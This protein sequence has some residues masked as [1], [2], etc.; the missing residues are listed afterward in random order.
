MK[1]IKKVSVYGLGNFGYAILKH[2]DNK[3]EKSFTL[4][5]YDRNLQLMNSLKKNRKHRFLHR[6]VKVSKMIRFESNVK[7]LVS[8][9]DV[10]ILAVNS[11]ATR[12]VI[13]KIKPHINQ[14]L[15]I[16]NTAKALD[17][18]TG[19]PIS[20]IVKHELKGIKYNYAVLAGGTI[21]NELFEHE[22]LGADIACENKKLLPALVD[23]F[24]GSSLAVYPTT[25]LIGV[26]YASALKNLISILAGIVK[27]LNFSYGSETHIISRMAYEIEKVVTTQLGGKKKTFSM[28]SQCW[29]NDLWMSS[30]G[31]TRNREFGILL[32]KG[33]S[34]ETSLEIMKKKR[35]TIEGYNTL[36]ALAKINLLKKYPLM[37]F[38]YEYIICK[39]TGIEKLLTLISKHEF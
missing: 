26:E 29:G 18:Q 11:E 27:G 2:L 14:E 19:K 8:D 6:S 22:P 13:R 10:L 5:G 16:V 9:C 3:D 32:G 35:K 21:S 24:Q 31:P 38:L 36:K 33:M 12:E 1:M 37:N 23:L 39:S 34:I 28:Q 30:T 15:T 4:H 7:N 17:Y 25:D 20:K